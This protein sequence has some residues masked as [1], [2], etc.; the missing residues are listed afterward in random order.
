MPLFIAPHNVELK[1]LKILTD[2]KTKKHLESLGLSVD[3]VVRVMNHAA[4][5]VV[6]LVKETRLALDGALA[7]KIF[8]K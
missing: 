3:G 4:G 5:S 7:T 2:D 8:V 6:L 1:I